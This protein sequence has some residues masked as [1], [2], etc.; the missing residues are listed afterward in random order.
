M[1]IALVVLA[2]LAIAL[3][4]AI[5]LGYFWPDVQ[6]QAVVVA[7]FWPFLLVVGP[8]LLFIGM[9]MLGVDLGRSFREVSLPP[10]PAKE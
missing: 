3:V 4:C 9:V 7:F 2:Y 5:S 1:L 8:V 10:P 6:E